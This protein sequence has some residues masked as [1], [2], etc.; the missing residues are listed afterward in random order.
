MIRLEGLGALKARFDA[1]RQAATSH[2]EAAAKAGALVVE[3]EAKR[4]CPVRSGHLRRSIH[5]EVVSR[6]LARVAVIV[7]TNVEYAL[8][9][10]YGTR[11]HEIR[12]KNGRA[13]H[14]AG[15]LH[16]VARVHHP[17]S[18]PRPFLRPAMDAHQHDA[19]AAVGGALAAALRGALG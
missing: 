12:A 6:S 18:A 13:L 4:L 14:W 8:H 3:N 15:A 10:E 9:V 5:A 2:L 16:P 17:G 1:A 19:A 11:P 7:G